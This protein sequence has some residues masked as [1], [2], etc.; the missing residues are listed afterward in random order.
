MSFCAAHTST[1][2]PHIREAGHFCVN[3]LGEDQEQLCRLFAV[4]GG[5]KFAGI[6]W[7]GAGTTGAPIIDDV[8]AWLDCTIEAQHEAGDHVI[9]VGRV[10]ELGLTHHEG[11]PLVF[12]RG[13]YGRFE[14]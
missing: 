2:W 11:K 5:D 8:L 7:K 13:G 4:T 14:A 1:T 6:G 3:V 9:V 10:H 12:F